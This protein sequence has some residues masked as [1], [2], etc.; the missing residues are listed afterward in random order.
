MQIE[1]LVT[2]VFGIL[3]SN[4]VGI[5]LHGSLAMGCFNPQRSD[6]D[7]LVRIHD[8]MVGEVKRQLGQMLLEISGSPC[9]IEISFLASGQIFPWRHPAPYDLHY[10]EAWRDDFSCALSSGEW[11]RWNDEL[12]TDADLAAHITVC[13]ERGICLTGLDTPDAFPGVPGADFLNSILADVLSPEFGL[14]SELKRPVYVVLNA[15]RTLA[16]LQHN[17]LLSKAEGAAWGLENLPEVHLPIIRQA[18]LVYQ[19][20]LDQSEVGLAAVR[21][22]AQDLEKAI[23]D[24]VQKRAANGSTFVR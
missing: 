15:C 24:E 17:L 13:G 5:Y 18:L 6:I 21:A 10:S 11:Q 8:P 16:F 23:L 14:R 3:D 4:L 19:G 9:P 12:W 22:L 7:I 20:A 1:R 2:A